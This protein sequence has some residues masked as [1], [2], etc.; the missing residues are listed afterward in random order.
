LITCAGLVAAALAGHVVPASADHKAYARNPLSMRLVY[1][2]KVLEFRD[3]RFSGLAWQNWGA[4]GT[5]SRATNRIVTCNP[6]C[7][8]GP[9]VNVGSA[10]TLTRLRR[11][12][13]RRVYT[14]MS[15]QDDQQVDPTIPPAVSIN[16]R[17]LRPC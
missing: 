12:G 17:T 5:T 13:N 16:P 3:A 2:P 11:S 9:V 1:K 4:E 7:A 10:V 14:C 8:D 15:W 6:S